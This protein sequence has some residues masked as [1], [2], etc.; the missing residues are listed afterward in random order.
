VND[1]GRVADEPYLVT[2]LIDGRSLA[3]E[4][5]QGRPDFRRSARWVAELAEALDHAHR[6]GMIHRHI[7]PSSVL[8]D[9]DGRAHLADFGL[10][11]DPSAEANLIVDGSMLGT[12][13]YM[14]PEQAR[15]GRRAIGAP[16][17][18][19][20]LGV[21]LYELLTGTRPFL[22]TARMVLMRIQEEAPRRP[23]KRDGSIPVDLE[24]ICLKCLR[25]SPADRYTTA[26]ALADDLRAFLGGRPIAA[27]R[28]SW[29]GRAARW[30]R[31]HSGIV[32]VSALCAASAR[33]AIGAWL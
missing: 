4:L 25:K 3:D 13:A 32:I 27:R 1:A 8:I 26:A 22:G 28:T 9:R 2:A 5:A 14:A 24:A 33:G 23:R 18:L 16:A 10:A 19:Y 7:K 31:R 29:L 11:R 30:A 12:P 6:R 21:V 15:G 20:S 17:D